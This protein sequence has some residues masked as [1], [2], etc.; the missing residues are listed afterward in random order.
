MQKT[1]DLP[2]IQGNIE[3]M[4]LRALESHE[5]AITAYGLANDAY[6]DD[7]MA[8]RQAV[9]VVTKRLKAE[10]E[11]VTIIGDLVRGETAEL[12]AAVLKSEGQMKR[13]KMLVLALEERIQA[14]KFIGRRLEVAVKG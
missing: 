11:K 2:T 9:A 10:G 4:L 12:K 14:I 6:A 1:Y 5:E 8:Y 3:Q 13:C 7:M